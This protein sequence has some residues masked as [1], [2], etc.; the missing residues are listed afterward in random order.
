[1]RTLIVPTVMVLTAVPVSQVLLGMA[2]FVE[3]CVI[4]NTESLCFLKKIL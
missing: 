2:L 3:V 4:C 1:M